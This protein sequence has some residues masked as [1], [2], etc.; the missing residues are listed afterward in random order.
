MKI[1]NTVAV[2]SGEE[3]VYPDPASQYLH[4]GLLNNPK[5]VEKQVGEMSPQ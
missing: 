5:A 2:E 3:D 1:K 4:N